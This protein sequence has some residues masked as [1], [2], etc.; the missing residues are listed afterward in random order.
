VAIAPDGRHVYTTNSESNSV[1][2]IDTITNVVSD[3]LDHKRSL[4][5]FGPD[6]VAM[7]PDGQDAYITNYGTN[8]VTV[9]DLG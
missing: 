7:S 5:Q 4:F 8:T 6:A 2:A 1:S 3:A 9:L